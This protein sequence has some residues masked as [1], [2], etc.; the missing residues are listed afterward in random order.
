MKTG[1]SIVFIAT[2]F[3]SVLLINTGCSN[4]SNQ[5]SENHKPKVIRLAYQLGHLPDII[6]KNKHWF[7]DE[8]AKDSI[9]IEYKKFD[10]GPPEIEAF[11][12]GQLD[13]GSI[14][15]QPSIIGWAR[16]VDIKIV[17]N[18]VGSETLMALLVP[19]NSPVTNFGQLKGKKIGI[20]VGSNI[21]HLFNIYLKQ[22]GLKQTDVDVVNLQFTECVNALSLHQIDATII[23][24]PYV[25]LAVYKKAGKII[26]YSK[27]IKYVTLPYIATNSFI[28]KYPEI[29]E[30]VLKVYRKASAWAKQNKEEAADILMHEENNLL[31]KEVELSLIDKYTENFGLNDSALNA[32]SATYKYLQE[33][34]ILKQQKDIKGLYEVKFDQQAKNEKK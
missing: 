4:H 29:V 30:R 5:A 14:G 24:E 12:A 19:E 28:D 15:D 23:G 32:F 34:G 20:T 26:G 9:A 31:P 1:K 16:G 22:Y 18:I 17:G 13:I 10:F 33:T 27:G 3:T 25:S 8:F 11:S 6:A 21:K 2:V 7:E